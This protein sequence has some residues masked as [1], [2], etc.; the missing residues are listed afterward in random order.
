MTKDTRLDRVRL[1][2]E[3]Q[4]S[5]IEAV[6]KKFKADDQKYNKLD[7]IYMLCVCPKGRNGAVNN[8]IAEVFYGASSYDEKITITKDLNTNKEFLVENG[9]TL[10][11]HLNDHGYVAIILHPSSTPYTKSIE[12]AIFVEDYIHPKKLND[13][14]FLKKQWNYLNSYMECTSIDGS[15]SLFDK[16]RCWKLRN[17]KSYSVGSDY[18]KSKLYSFSQEVFKWVL[19]V[20]LSGL[21]IYIFTVFPNNNTSDEYIKKQNKE[22]EE[23]KVLLQEY[24]NI[25][26][27][28]LIDTIGKVP[29]TPHLYKSRSENI[30]YN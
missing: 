12:S 22:L 2:Q 7:D 18:Q 15:P 26:K 3:F 21:L 13:I 27:T 25:Q 30:M 9:A 29:P 28:N 8:R 10:A 6:F 11:F 16:Y 19:T 5:K 17:F 20:G 23:I 1:F 24:T 4:T 14:S